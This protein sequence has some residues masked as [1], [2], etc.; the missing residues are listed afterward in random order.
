MLLDELRVYGLWQTLPRPHA[1]EWGHEGGQRMDL[2]TASSTAR[3]VLD[4]KVDIHF[5]F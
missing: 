4:W 1:P 5:I 2:R 3:E